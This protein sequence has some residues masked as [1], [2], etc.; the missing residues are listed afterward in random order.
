MTQPVEPKTPLAGESRKAEKKKL[1]Y[2]RTVLLV[3]FF[4]FLIAVMVM[5]KLNK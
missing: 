5:A 1:S 4:V 3:L 2:L